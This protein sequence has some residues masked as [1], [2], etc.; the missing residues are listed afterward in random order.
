MRLE[1]TVISNL[2]Y[3]EDYTRRVLPFLKPDYFQDQTEKVL[4]QEIDKFV[5]KY[6]GLPTKETLLIELNKRNDI[7]EN[8]FASIIEYID[9]LTFEKKDSDWLLDSTEEFCKQKAIYNAIVNSIEILDG[10]SQNVDRGNIPTLLTEAL[11]VSFDDHIG[12]D[13]I[14]NADERY[15]FY[16]RK[17]DKVAF[18]LEYFNLIT[19][20][21]LPNKTLNIVMAPTGAGKSLFMCHFAAANMLAGKNVLY[22]T[23][24]MAEERIAQ[25]I[26]ANLLNIPISELE[27]FPKK[28]YDDKMNKLRLKTGGKLIVKEYPTAT[29][30]SAHFRH[31]LNELHLKKNFRPDI[32][33][34]DY[35]NICSSARLKFGANVNS[36]SYIKAIAEE[37]RGLAVEKN[38]PIVSATQ[39]NRSGS[40]NSDPGLEDT[41]ESFGLP[42]TVD[43]M[44]TL[45]STEEMENLGQ[46]MVK[47]LKNR[48]NDIT[49]NKRFVVGIDRTKMRLFNTEQSAQEDIMKDT[50]VM[51]NSTYGER[52]KEE[53]QMKWMTKKAGK[54]DFSNLV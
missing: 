9:D 23:L 24:E 33:Y 34:I 30:G 25:R 4:F 47:Q 1:Q 48:Y 19:G 38:L 46:I 13:F 36:Y 28:I 18:D 49:T 26:D 35:L 40:T 44:C 41:S 39:I 6:N 42:A 52:H 10:N 15:E 21:G 16:N 2:I 43:F 29:A 50:P 31:L 5:E 3:D 37:L 17:E 32:I 14:E 22:I 51:D 7:P 27:G 45:I 20:G 53:E 12:H 11:G 8:T 54:R